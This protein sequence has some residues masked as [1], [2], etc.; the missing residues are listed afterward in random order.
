MLHELMAFPRFYVFFFR[1]NDDEHQ[2]VRC[3]CKLNE[4]EAAQEIKAREA[5]LGFSVEVVNV[6]PAEAPNVKLYKPRKRN[7]NELRDGLDYR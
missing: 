1:D 2:F 6:L 7:K 4:W 5:G 3:A